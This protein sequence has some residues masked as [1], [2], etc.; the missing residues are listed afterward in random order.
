MNQL[1]LM[2]NNDVALLPSVL[3]AN[4]CP[5]WGNTCWW[6]LYSALRSPRCSPIHISDRSAPTSCSAHTAR[7]IIIT[8]ILWWLWWLP[9]CRWPLWWVWWTLLSR[10]WPLARWRHCSPLRPRWRHRCALTL[11]NS[12]RS[13]KVRP[14]PKTRLLLS[15]VG[16]F[17]LQKKCCYD[18]SVMQLF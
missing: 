5:V 1:F 4:S 10:W 11:P 8:S 7:T 12:S 17:Q 9:C 15:Q 3:S 14:N 6:Q 16:A 2:D 18:R 13:L